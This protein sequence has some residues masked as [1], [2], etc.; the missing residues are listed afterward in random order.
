MIPL[1]RASFCVAEEIIFD[2]N[3]GPVCPVC[4][5]RQVVPLSRWLKPMPVPVEVSPLDLLALA[6]SQGIELKKEYLT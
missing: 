1:V 6:E 3:S 2:R 4:G 5:S